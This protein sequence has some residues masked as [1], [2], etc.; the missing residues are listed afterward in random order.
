MK[1][2]K[3]ILALTALVSFL[4]I[5]IIVTVLIMDGINSSANSTGFSHKKDAHSK[6]S[7]HPEEETHDVHD[8]EHEGE[9]DDEH[10]EHGQA[11]ADGKHDEEE[12]GFVHLSEEEIEEF[13]IKIDRVEPGELDLYVELPGEIV[14]NSDRQAHVVPNVS[15]IVRS[16]SKKLGD[17]V[18]KGEVMA[19]IESRELADAKAEFMAARERFEMAEVNL[20]REKN[21]WEKKISAEQDYFNARQVFVESRIA[22][23]SAEQKLHILGFSEDYLNRL[24]EHSDTALTRYEIRAPFSGTVIQ[25]HITLGEALKDDAQAFVVADLSTVWV[26][27]SVYQKDLTRITEGQK[28]VIDGGQSIPYTEGDISYV[29]PLVGESTRT[30]LAR[31]VLP[32]PDGK[33]RPGMFVSVK[34]AVDNIKVPFRILKSALQTIEDEPVVFVKEEDGFLPKTVRIGQ[35]NGRYVEIIS[36]L[37]QG[38]YYASQNPF[39]LKAQISKNGFDDGHNH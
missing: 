26:D 29:G 20:S 24:P 14:I 18:E 15:G 33:L 34:V 3:N 16:V 37:K 21:L 2:K 30:A 38:E 22:L 32:N 36:G 13:N 10:D 23:R 35:G 6:H 25:K 17:R 1:N 19:V 28:A 7:D 5:G 31:I 39:T 12:E 8:D 4:T 27:I 11:E 9:T